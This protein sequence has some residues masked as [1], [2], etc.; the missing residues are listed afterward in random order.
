MSEI[1]MFDWGKI[2]T[3]DGNVWYKIILREPTIFP[4]QPLPILIAIRNPPAG[5]LSEFTTKNL[6]KGVKRACELILELCKYVTTLSAEELKRQN[7][8][9]EIDLA[10]KYLDITTAPN[11]PEYD[12]DLFKDELLRFCNIF[13]TLPAAELEK[14]I[15]DGG[16]DLLI[17]FPEYRMNPWHVPKGYIHE[18][19]IT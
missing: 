15:R 10:F 12:P 6:P 7:E 9:R 3:F 14:R 16:I 17:S 11:P 1:M 8:N 5:L 2:R 19:E 4:D 13:I 18:I